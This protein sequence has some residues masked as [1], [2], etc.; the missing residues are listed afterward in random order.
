MKKVPICI[1]MRPMLID[2]VDELARQAGLS[3]SELKGRLLGTFVSDLLQPEI[4]WVKI[5]RDKLFRILKV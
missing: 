1:G 2:Q 5:K 3:R 4:A